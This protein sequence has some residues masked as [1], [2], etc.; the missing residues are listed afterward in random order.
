MRSGEHS[1]PLHA[2]APS[3]S[4]NVK[5]EENLPPLTP[6]RP[7]H[8][9]TPPPDDRATTLTPEPEMASNTLPAILDRDS[10]AQN[11]YNGYYAPAVNRILKP[12]FFAAIGFSIPISKM[13]Q[14]PVIWR[15]LAYATLMAVS[16]LCCGLWLVRF[17]TASP[18][19]QA[20]KRELVPATREL[21]NRNKSPRTRW[22]NPLPR[23]KSL[24]PASILGCAMVARGE[25]GF[26]IA[27]LAATNGIFTNHNA[28]TSETSSLTS[29]LYLVVMWAILLCT[30]FGPLALGVLAKRVRRLQEDG[31]RDS[32]Q[33]NREDPL[34]IWGIK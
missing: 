24:Y 14:G 15:G 33:G 27:A 25:I 10:R 1:P 26:L 28:A 8:E 20:A 3:F 2:S 18:R 21:Q 12:F 6:S 23:P 34:G 19:S 29:E 9:L 32:G 16:K 31:A 22:Q 4:V 7:S 11:M 17:T 30:I 13:F 5:N